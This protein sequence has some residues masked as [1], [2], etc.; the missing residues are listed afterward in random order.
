MVQIS[1]AFEILGGLGLLIPALR[2]AA[3]WG[4]VALLIAVFPANIY[5]VTDP[6]A[7]GAA[8]ISPLVL[9]G[10]LPLQLVFI[11]W[12]LWATRPAIVPEHGRVAIS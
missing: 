8:S 7:V 11:A 2:R 4:L 1:G 10:R 6:V 3:A 12:V 5:M 9:W